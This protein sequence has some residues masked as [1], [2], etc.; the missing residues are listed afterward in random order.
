MSH[1]ADIRDK[2]PGEVCDRPNPF[3]KNLPGAITCA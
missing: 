2:P 3:Y 1:R